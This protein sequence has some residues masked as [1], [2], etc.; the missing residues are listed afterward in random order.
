MSRAERRTYHNLAQ[1]RPFPRAILEPL[2]TSHFVYG[3]SDIEAAECP[4]PVQ[5]RLDQQAVFLSV[6][7][8]P[9]SVAV[10]LHGL[11]SRL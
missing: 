3:N 6:E 4:F 5:S 10:K 1:P 7:A 11:V 2:V 9:I 8:L